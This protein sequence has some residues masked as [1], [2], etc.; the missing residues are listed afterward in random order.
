MRGGKRQGAGRPLGSSHKPK[1]TDD[2]TEKQKKALLLRS[3]E[4]AMAGDS[5]LAIFFMEQLYGKATQVLEGSSD[6][7][8]LIIEKIYYGEKNKNSV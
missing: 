2:L 5:K 4:L 6:G 1:M 8:P 3:Y 7:T